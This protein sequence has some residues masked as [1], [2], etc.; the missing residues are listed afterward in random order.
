MEKEMEPRKNGFTILDV[1]RA[2]LR[3]INCVF[4]A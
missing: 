1:T 2:H 4:D 3:Q